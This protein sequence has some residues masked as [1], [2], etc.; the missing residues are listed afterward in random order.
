MIPRLDG[1][2]FVG[3]RFSMVARQTLEK[4]LSHSLYIWFDGYESCHPKR[5]LQDVQGDVAASFAGMDLWG[6]DLWVSMGPHH[7]HLCLQSWFFEWMRQEH[8]H[9]FFPIHPG[10][11]TWN[12]QI[13]HLE[14][15]MIFQTIIFRFHVSLPGCTLYATSQDISY[16][17]HRP[18]FTVIHHP[19]VVNA[20]HVGVSLEP[21]PAD[22][23]T[24][25][26]SVCWL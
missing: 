17:H 7:A 26:W 21:G 1:K 10:R 12:L 6:L 13:T 14:R 8:A 3:D 24:E 22:K 5:I 19:Q 18:T 4:D 9:S 16:I 11:L 20:A 25:R 2:P 15:K 23:S